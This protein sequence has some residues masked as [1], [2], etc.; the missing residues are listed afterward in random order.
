MNKPDNKALDDLAN[1][2]E[3]MNKS[4]NNK[5]NKKTT[6]KKKRPIRN[7]RIKSN[8]VN[9]ENLNKV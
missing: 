6:L 3:N 9:D 5:S 7:L 1:I 4:G 2:V 8:E